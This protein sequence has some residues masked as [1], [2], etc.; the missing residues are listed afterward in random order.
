MLNQVYVFRSLYQEPIGR[1]G[2]CIHILKH[3]SISLSIE[4]SNDTIY[5][6]CRDIVEDDAVCC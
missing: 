1:G 3:S 5:Y 6:L 2:A 4:E